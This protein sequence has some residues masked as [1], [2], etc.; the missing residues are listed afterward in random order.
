MQTSDTVM[1]PIVSQAVKAPKNDSILSDENEIIADSSLYVGEIFMF[2]ETGELYTSVY[3]LEELVSDEVFDDLNTLAD[4]LIYEDQEIRRRRIPIS[5]ARQYFSL[6]ALDTLSVYKNGHRVG[7]AKFVRVEYLDDVIESRFIAVFKPLGSFTVA[8][9]PDYGIS[10]GKHPYR[11]IP[12][13][14][15]EIKDEQLTK[16]LIEIFVPDTVRVWDVSH[17][18]IMPYH[19]IY[20]VI[21]M[22][23]RLLLVETHEGQSRILKDLKE[24]FF[25]SDLQ[26]LHLESNG[27]PILLLTMGLNE[28]D[29]MWHSVAVFSGEEFVFTEGNRVGF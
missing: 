2:R 14:H 9:E 4:S 20:S 3:F 8:E 5:I 23:S 16:N 12:V 26:P 13:T 27:K 15:E 18:H 21:S 22:Q 29:M 6:W 10:K 25:I 7:D 1:V 28:T 24:D 19:S 17:T 11:T